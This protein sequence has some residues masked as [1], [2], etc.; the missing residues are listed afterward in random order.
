MTLINKT[1][2]YNPVYE[3]PYLKYVYTQKSPLCIYIR[4]QITVQYKF[5]LRT[6][7]VV[8]Q[9][10]FKHLTNMADNKHMWMTILTS[11]Q[12]TQ[13]KGLPPK[14]EKYLTAWHRID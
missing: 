13:A 11:T 4:Q 3:K 1:L 5:M 7:T 6:E 10:L 8:E 12:E 14:Q 2:F 9:A